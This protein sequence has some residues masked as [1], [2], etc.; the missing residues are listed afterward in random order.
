MQ[1]VVSRQDQILRSRPLFMLYL[2][3]PAPLIDLFGYARQQPASISN[4]ESLDSH[5]TRLGLATSQGNSM[6]Q[7]GFNN[8]THTTIGYIII[9]VVVGTAPTR[10]SK[11]A[12]WPH[13]VYP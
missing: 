9:Q 11:A 8:S 12:N 13:D 5:R 6:F 3:N 4:F 10:V 7:L 2:Y 1:D